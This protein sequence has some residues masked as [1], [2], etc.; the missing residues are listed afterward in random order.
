MKINKK[1]LLLL[2]VMLVLGIS[3]G[4]TDSKNTNCEDEFIFSEEDFQNLLIEM[5]QIVKH[6]IETL[7][8]TYG[9]DNNEME[10]DPLIK[11]YRFYN[12]SDLT[13]EQREKIDATLNLS[14]TKSLYLV[15]PTDKELKDKMYKASKKYAEL[16]DKDYDLRDLI[17]K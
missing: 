14:T 15:V 10:K 2:I 11:K 16:V 12:N 3:G 5:G 8:D 7:T 9:A 17:Y 6:D 1:L 13:S 4:C